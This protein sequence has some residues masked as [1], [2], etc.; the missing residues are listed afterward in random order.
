VAFT[1]ERKNRGWVFKK[2]V[3]KVMV[4]YKLEAAAKGWRKL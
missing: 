1:A 2:I 4:W 3:V